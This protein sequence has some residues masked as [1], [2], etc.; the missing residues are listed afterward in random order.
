MSAEMADRVPVAREIVA[1]QRARRAGRPMDKTEL[2]TLMTGVLAGLC[3]IGTFALALV[4]GNVPAEV[5]ALDATIFGFYGGT[6]A[7]IGQGGAG[8]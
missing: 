7:R 2:Q 8:G 3:L 6:L 1:V 5:V 4:H